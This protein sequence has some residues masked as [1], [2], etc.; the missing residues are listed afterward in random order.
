MIVGQVSTLT[1]Q[2]TIFEGI[3]GAQELDPVL[4]WFVIGEK[5]IA[6]PDFIESMKEAI[7]LIIERMETAQSRQKCYVDK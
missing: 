2:P 4:H 7:K 6:T 5:Q 1:L 3:Q